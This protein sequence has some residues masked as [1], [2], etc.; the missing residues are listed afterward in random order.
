MSNVWSNTAARFISTMSIFEADG[1][2]LP[3]PARLWNFFQRDSLEN[4]TR[5]L[6]EVEAW[7]TSESSFSDLQ[8]FSFHLRPWFLY[9]SRVVKYLKYSNRIRLCI[10]SK[11]D[12]QKWDTRRSPSSI[13]IRSRTVD[14]QSEVVC[15]SS[16]S[17]M[18]VTFPTLSLCSLYSQSY[19]FP[20]EGYTKHLSWSSDDIDTVP[21]CPGFQACGRKIINTTFLFTGTSLIA[22]GCAIQNLGKMVIGLGN[23]FLHVWDNSWAFVPTHH[24]KYLK[25]GKNT[26]RRREENGR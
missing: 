20:F 22:A 21:C 12:N 14:S 24:S 5:R 15:P 2:T 7:G 25:K 23:T 16:L 19:H 10:L 1:L 4:D 9:P 3:T 18:P 11:H 6:I 8:V 13:W 17:F 26:E